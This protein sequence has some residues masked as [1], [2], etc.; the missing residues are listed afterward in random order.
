MPGCADTFLTYVRVKV[1]WLCYVGM[2]AMEGLVIMILLVN[3]E[4][5]CNFVPF[6]QTAIMP[7]QVVLSFVTQFASG[8][9]TDHTAPYAHRVLQVTCGLCLVMDALLFLVGKYS[10]W[11]LLALFGL[12]FTSLV[13][14]NNSVG[15]VLK[16]HLNRTNVSEEDQLPIAAN[17]FVVTECGGRFCAVTFGFAV[18]LI[19]VDFFHADFNTIMLFSFGT[20]FALDCTA[21]T[22]ALFIPSSYI[23]GPQ[24]K[25][26]IEEHSEL[27]DES[28]F[29][30]KKHT[31]CWRSLRNSFGEFF[32]HK[33]IWM[34]TIQI[35]LG[36]LVMSLLSVIM[37]FELAS[38]PDSHAPKHRSNLC[39]MFLRNLLLQDLVGD[40]IRALSAIFY[41]FVLT[42]MRP[43][44]FF[45]R[46]WFCITAVIGGLIASTYW[47]SMPPALGSIV[48]GLLQ[49][50]IYMLLVFANST[51]TAV[52]PET[53]YGL[54]FAIQ[55]GLNTLVLLIPSGLS[56]LKL[57]RFALTTILLALLLASVFW[58]IALV[59]YN[60]AA[61]LKL[62]IADSGAKN[63]C[64]S[65]LWGYDVRY[66]PGGKDDEEEIIEDSDSSGY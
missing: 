31:S 9:F 36:I 50:I 48:L 62:D 30:V 35:V 45:S 24:M 1:V 55:G 22:T 63:R 61:I 3:S 17:V 66:D 20:I 19:L 14:L 47:T 29:N 34:T 65:C 52:V 57:P 58:S 27:I 54:S 60:K 37:R 32:H 46:I 13:Q 23:N 18:P 53:I 21:F 41:Q 2:N 39:N 49:A 11:I 25:K 40:G 38:V 59:Y 16:L 8:I 28:E 26:E 4:L 56:A 42:H 64:Q 15:K 10:Q 33:L 6:Y 44:Y 51:I 43:W 7:T 5:A 12:R